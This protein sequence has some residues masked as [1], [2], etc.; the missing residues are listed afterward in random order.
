M[1]KT[2][3]PRE[4]II[5]FATI[6]VVLFSVIFKVAIAPIMDKN[7]ALNRQINA[8]RAKLKKYMRLVAQKEAIQKKYSELSSGVS[9][10][11][12]EAGTVVGVLS[13]LEALAGKAGIR[14][15]DIRPQSTRGPKEVLID[16][17]AEG[18][19]QG[20][21]KFIYYVE[22][23]LSSLSVKKFQLNAKPN[24]ALLEGVFTISQAPN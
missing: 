13:E 19:V 14:I 20:Y 3:N 6:A 5:L 17:R 1:K 2:I 12:Q 11:E 22:Q 21:L 4:K 10:P 18:D 9:I 16:M 23:S 24:S 15:I 7:E 8:T